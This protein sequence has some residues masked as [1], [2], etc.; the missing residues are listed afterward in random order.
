MLILLTGGSAC[1]KSAYGEKMAVLGPKPLY[2][3]A[4]MQPYDDECL[5]KIARH[6]ELRKG[7]GFTTVERYT[8]VD[9]LHLP[10]TGG[11]ALL[12]CLCNLTANEMYIQPNSPVDPVEKVLTGVENLRRQTDT[13]IVITND[14]GSDNEEY[15]EE[16]RAY[17]RYIGEINARVAA[18]ADRVY[19][20]VAGI[21]LC[22]KGGTA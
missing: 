16:T 21:P 2:Y 22:L 4:A 11:T 10:Q 18:M 8:G 20:L 12:E 13:L 15:S 3:I 9:S 14:V 1:G 5:R 17:I 7:K 19:E 6:K